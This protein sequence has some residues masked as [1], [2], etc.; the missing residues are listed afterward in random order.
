MKYKRVYEKEG[1]ERTVV[2]RLDSGDF[3]VVIEKYDNNL[4]AWK[5]EESTIISE[6]L[7]WIIYEL[8]NQD[9]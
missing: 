8:L 9:E 3:Q 1:K 2:E 6:E 5:E 4:K 7:A